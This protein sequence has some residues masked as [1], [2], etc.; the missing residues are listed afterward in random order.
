MFY[1][2]AICGEN[3]KNLYEESVIE[4][5]KKT[6]FNWKLK[7]NL[8]NLIALLPKSLSYEVYFQV[9]RRFGG[10]KKPFNP[11]N[12][13]STAADLLKK[14]REYGFSAKGKIFFEVGTGKAPIIPIAYWLGGAGRIIT[15]DLNPYMRKEIIEDM[16]FYI[17]KE[18]G[19]IARIFG[20]L[21]EKERLLA[22]LEYG[23]S[24]KINVGELLKMCGI[25]YIAPG[26]A[27][28]TALLKNSV[29]YHT[30]NAVY[31]HIPR[32]TLKNIL[33]EG[34][35]ITKPDGLFI[36]IIDYSD[37][38]T[39]MGN[40]ISSINF[41]QFDEKEWDRYAGNRYMYMNRLRHD[42]F[43]GL[44]EEAGH[45]II[46]VEITRDDEVEKLLKEGRIKINERFAHK[47]NEILS[48]IGSRFITKKNL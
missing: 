20:G 1:A 10:L 47:G 33:E 34:N 43:L 21:L 19:Q 45:E 16:L 48:I 13:I 22:L 14:I 40:E 42:D 38:F 6:N 26:D 7:A 9:Q 37:H 36:N 30:S 17:S 29:D 46:D 3:V 12:H 24:G 39:Q 25:E 2:F 15:V 31:E 5:M 11:M 44:F 4:F 35:R 28:R 23:K 32:T 27:S 41:L 18:T 8:Q